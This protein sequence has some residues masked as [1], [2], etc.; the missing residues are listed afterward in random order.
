MRYEERGK[1]KP[2]AGFGE[3]KSGI[4]RFPEGHL[5]GTRA[6]F[7]DD[8]EG[9]SEMSVEDSF[10][11]LESRASGSLALTLRGKSFVKRVFTVP[12]GG[13]LRLRYVSV[14]SASTVEDTIHLGEGARLEYDGR[15]KVGAG[16]FIN[17]LRVVHSR[18]DSSS[19]VSL[20]GVVRG[21]AT[22]L[23]TGEFLPGARGSSTSIKGAVFLFGGG[24]ADAVPKLLIGDPRTRAYHSFKKFQ[25]N[26]EQLFYMT[27]RGLGENN[28]E[29][30][31]E[32]FMMGV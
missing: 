5:E 1:L 2:P 23:P 32:K 7:V 24:K 20:R 9:D 17:R 27:S 14:D 10:I 19:E 8:F 21:G 11:G 31:Y 15:F 4:R 22:L 26:P 29:S 30:L 25:M 16:R 3:F 6:L 18:P 13:E 28:I 12:D